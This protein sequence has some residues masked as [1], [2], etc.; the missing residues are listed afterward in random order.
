MARPKKS[1]LSLLAVL[2]L[3]GC[4]SRAAAAIQP[5]ALTEV[6]AP[7]GTAPAAPAGWTRVFADDFPGTAG[8]APSSANWFHDL[9][10]GFG[11]GAVQ[12]AT[13]STKNAYLDGSGHL[14]LKAF[15]TSN[16]TWQSA[17]LESTRD[18][19]KAPAGGELKMTASIRLPSAA[20][21]LGYWPAF[22]ALGAPN[23]T[24]GSWPSTGE[25]DMMEAING[26]PGAS[27][28]LHD[29]AGSTGH[30]LVS[31]AG[32]CRSGYH[33]F[34]AIVNRTKTS[35][36]YLQ[37]LIDGKVIQT[38]TEAK[39]GV[40]AWQKAIDHGFYFVLDLTLGGSYPDGECNCTTPT[41]ATTSGGS[42]SLGYVAV[43]EKGGNSTPTAKATAAG[44]MT[45][46]EGMC[47]ANQN[48]L[49]VAGNPIALRSCASLAGEQWSFYSD[50]TLRV[51]GGCLDDVKGTTSSGAWLDWYPCNGTGDQVWTHKSNGEFVNPR[52]G[53]CLADPLGNTSARIVIETCN[54]DATQR[55]AI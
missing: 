40:A 27:Q 24:G 41:S 6:K 32:D 4:A 30:Y 1:L 46:Y 51:Q 29:A 49:N 19:F 10:T 18:D 14:V 52:T 37:F 15:R 35:A 54:D 28:A 20:N 55:W 44:H 53:L 3:A 5:M 23:R 38:I 7:A 42:M 17:R 33:T 12:Q 36:E 22:A 48:S 8:K 39:V 13:N 43:Y 31:C 50:G 9:G 34:S 16:G 11:D 26:W 21:A 47:L 2:F 45:G 25:I